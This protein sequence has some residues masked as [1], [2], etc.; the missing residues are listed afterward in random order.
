MRGLAAP[1]RR[2]ANVP[3]E[4]FT[5]D[6]PTDDLGTAATDPAGT[7]AQRS[8]V[9]PA[10][11]GLVT[12]VGQ[13]TVGADDDTPTAEGDGG[14]A[15]GSFTDGVRVWY[16]GDYDYAGF[17][18]RLM[19][20]LNDVRGIPTEGK[21]L[22]IVAA[23]KY[24]LHFRILNGNGKAV[25]DTNEAGLAEQARQIKALKVRLEDLWPPHELTRND[26]DWVIAAVTSIIGHTHYARRHRLRHERLIDV[27]QER[28]SNRSFGLKINLLHS[29]CLFAFLLYNQFV[30]L[31][32]LEGALIAFI[33][34]YIGGELMLR[35]A[36]D[37]YITSIER[38]AE[39]RKKYVTYALEGRNFAVF[40]RDSS[41][42]KGGLYSDD[43]ITYVDYYNDPLET[44]II[45]KLSKYLPFVAL[46]NP[47]YKNPYPAADRI[48]TE[49]SNWELIIEGYII[50]SAIIVILIDSLSDGVCSEIELIR[51]HS[52][53]GQ[54]FLLYDEELG[55][56]LAARHATFFENVRW[57]VSH[58][59]RSRL[60]V[61]TRGVG[62]EVEK[63]ERHLAAMRAPLVRDVIF[64]NPAY[65]SLEDAYFRLEESLYMVPANDGSPLLIEF[66]TNG[67]KFY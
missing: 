4:V 16:F 30:M 61:W 38:E 47:Q 17:D 64:R 58:Q 18:L 24:R 3:Y 14:A 62:S 6:A 15:P 45:E 21:N 20:S 42:E 7:L 5:V 31:T 39:N 34:Y 48:W 32:S 59:G 37:G 13:T 54:T 46:A 27:K 53:Q 40:L 55:A 57:K 8:G 19:S 1:Q 44:F 49:M 65:A 51:K 12:G 28:R 23:V 50:H 66:I 41:H 33:F 11:P 10:S 9:V 60:E 22:I 2:V 56:Q 52:L 29:V 36:T 67:V 25:V 35:K 26:K 63:L 43:G